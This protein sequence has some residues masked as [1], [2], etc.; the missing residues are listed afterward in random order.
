MTRFEITEQR[1]ESIRKAC[2]TKGCAPFICI[3]TKPTD[4]VMQDPNLVFWVIPGVEVSE[5]RRVLKF[6]L[7]QLGGA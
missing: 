7:D 5:I 3:G 1:I 2:A 4:D 6:C